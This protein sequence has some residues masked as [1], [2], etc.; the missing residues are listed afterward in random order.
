MSYASILPCPSSVTFSTTITPSPTIL[1]LT[2]SYHPLTLLFFH[3]PSQSRA[4]LPFLFSLNSI[5]QTFLLFHCLPLHQ[6]PKRSTPN[7]LST[8]QCGIELSW[9]KTHKLT[10]MV[11]ERSR[12]IWGTILEAMTAADEL[13]IDNKGKGGIEDDA[14]GARLKNRWDIYW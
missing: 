1:F 8:K 13:D 2:D 4:S 12:L 6:F 11:M 9:R 14:E 10:V 3:Y 5:V 7:S